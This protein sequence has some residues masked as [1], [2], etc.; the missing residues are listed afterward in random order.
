MP[1]KNRQED[2]R[3][4][5]FLFYNTHTLHH[6][7]DSISEENLFVHGVRDFLEWTV[8]FGTPR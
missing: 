6:R 1:N 4:H 2:T 7:A 3:I 8:G 5:H